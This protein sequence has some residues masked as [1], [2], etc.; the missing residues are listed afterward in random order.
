MRDVLRF[1]SP[2]S[3]EQGDIDVARGSQTYLGAR[4]SAR[5]HDDGW[6]VHPAPRGRCGRS[7]FPGHPLLPAL[8][9]AALRLTVVLREPTAVV[10]GID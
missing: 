8:Q 3:V 10:V 6:G 2:F 9:G 7:V 5:R 4:A 1:V